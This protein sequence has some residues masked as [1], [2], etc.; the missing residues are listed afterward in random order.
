MTH[1]LVV[2]G[3]IA[4]LAAAQRLRERG[5][6]QVRVTVVEQT[7]R[8]GGKIRT[9][10]FAGRPI[11]SGAETFL[12][13]RDEGVD[14]ARKVGLGEQLA[15]PAALPPGLAVAGAVR[16]LPRR[17]VMGVP[18][19]AADVAEI[20]GADGRKRMAS[21]PDSGE[22]LLGAEEDVSV[23]RLVRGRF[24]DEVVDRLVDPLLGGV[25]AGRADDLSLEATVPA[26]AA[27]A[28]KHSTLAGAV[29]QCLPAPAGKTPAPVFGTIQGGLSR[30]VDAAADAAR[31]DVRLGLPVRELLRVPHGWRAV[32]GDTRAPQVI[33]ADAVVLAVPARPAARLL[34][35]LSSTASAAIGELD[36]ASVALVALALPAADLPRR[37]GIL[38]PA[39]EGFGVKAA[40]FFNRKWPHIDSGELSLVRA[41]VGR[42]GEESLLQRDDADLAALAH[43]ELSTLLGERLPQPAETAVHRWGG[44]LPQ[45][46]PGHADRIRRARAAL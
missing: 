25:Y 41:S 31:A 10:E 9:E 2:G 16:D 3:G 20:V 7:G 42:Y 30:M 36:Y 23:G 24:G 39:V 5:G 18:A 38:V 37:S 6:E 15:H 29:R 28:R 35:D 27:A 12:V 21:E 17:T 11:E 45:Y 32:V 26:L 40:T 33:E 19:D 8:L 1:V 34:A 14:L 46:G 43:A 4:G 22:P 13:R 44:G